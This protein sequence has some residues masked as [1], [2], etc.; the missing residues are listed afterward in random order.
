MESKKKNYKKKS[1]K[2]EKEVYKDPPRPY[3]WFNDFQM[4]GKKN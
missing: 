1:D 4:G 2:K 3:F